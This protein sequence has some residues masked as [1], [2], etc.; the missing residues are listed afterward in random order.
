LTCKYNSFLHTCVE[1][2]DEAHPGP[3]DLSNQGV[4]PSGGRLVG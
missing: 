3:Q 4:V 1:V 2:G